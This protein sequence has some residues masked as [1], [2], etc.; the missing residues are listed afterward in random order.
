MTS[1]LKHKGFQS[2]NG[3]LPLTVKVKQIFNLF[4]NS[5]ILC[6]FV[7]C[8]YCMVR[9]GNLT[10]KVSLCTWKCEGVCVYSSIHAQWNVLSQTPLG[11]W[12]SPSY[13]KC[14]C[15]IQLVMRKHL[16]MSILVDCLMKATFIFSTHDMDRISLKSHILFWFILI[17]INISFCVKHVSYTANHCFRLWFLTTRAVKMT[18]SGIQMLLMGRCCGFF[19]DIFGGLNV[20]G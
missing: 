12:Y 20:G 8:L 10:L 19:G 11:H 4:M 3:I 9:G 6:C 18:V 13:S 7:T 1:E 2:N 17:Y 15:L 16:R 14:K 5:T